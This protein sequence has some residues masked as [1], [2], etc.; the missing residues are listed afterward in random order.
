MRNPGKNICFVTTNIPSD[1]LL[2]NQISAIAFN[3]I[4]IIPTILLNAIA[5]ITIL[6]SSQLKK[7]YI[8]FTGWEVR[9]GKRSS[10]GLRSGRGRRPRDASETEG[11]YFSLRTDVLFLLRNT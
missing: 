1:T 4:L 5:I 7:K 10:R 2:I 11:R 8:L 3:G 6:K 9:T